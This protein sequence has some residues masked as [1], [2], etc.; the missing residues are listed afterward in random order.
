MARS[1]LD[2]RVRRLRDQVDERALRWRCGFVHGLDHGFVLVRAGDGQHGGE[3]RADQLRF[4]AHA[5]GHDHAAVFGNRLANRG[6]AFFLGGIEEPAGVDQHDVGPGIVRAHGI[7]IGAQPGEDAFAVDQR[8]GTAQA[9]HADFTRFRNLDCH[10][11]G[12]Y[13][14]CGQFATVVV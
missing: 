11:R 9:D 12:P 13:T 6:Q 10:G 3:L 14:D 7:A 2:V 5:P 1:Q 4:A 8:L